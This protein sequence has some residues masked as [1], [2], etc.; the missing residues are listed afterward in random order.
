MILQPAFVG[1]T[2]A[3][4]RAPKTVDVDHP[5]QRRPPHDPSPYWLRNTIVFVV[6]A[7]WVTG[8]AVSII[9]P[10]FSIPAPVH[11]A[12]LMI[13]GAV[14]GVSFRRQGIE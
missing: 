10:E 3:P 5:R 12:A 4:R 2:P 7:M 9:N 1:A 14:F 13:I 6:L 11:T 8:F